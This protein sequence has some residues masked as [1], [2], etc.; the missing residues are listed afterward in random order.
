ML[1]R[2]KETLNK[3]DE[4][5]QVQGKIIETILAIRREQGKNDIPFPASEQA[6]SIE[7][8]VE[9]YIENPNN[10]ECL[11]QLMRSFWTK[12]DEKSG[13]TTMVPEFPLKSKEIKKRA[14]QNQMAIFNG[15]EWV[16][17][18]KLANA[19]NLGTTE[20]QFKKKLGKGGRQII[21][22]KS[23]KVGGE[24]HK[25]LYGIYFDQEGARSRVLNAYGQIVDAY[26]IDGGG[27]CVRCRSL[28]SERCRDYL[29]GRF[30]EVIKKP[31]K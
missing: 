1:G 30:E 13:K 9:K 19:P 14:K 11:T 17:I 3:G 16:W 24:I 6:L 25:L 27:M 8:A 4:F 15:D 21:T 22:L 2:L 31:I 26:F 28:P 7:E 5:D 10:S 20:S 18:E 12:A 23:Y 29:G